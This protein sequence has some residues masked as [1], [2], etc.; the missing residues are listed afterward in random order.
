MLSLLLAN[1]MAFIILFPG[2]LLSIAIHEFAHA[3]SADKLG[4]PTPRLQGRV[5][6]NPLSHLDPIGTLMIFL[7]SFGWG[8]AVEFDPYNLKH[9]VRDTALIAL[10][11]PVANLLIALVLS[12]VIRTGILPWAWMYEAS[13]LI[14]YINVA[15]AIFNLVPVYPLDGSKILLALLPRSTAFEYDQFM[16]RY[17]FLV[18]I[19]LIFPFV[20]GVSPVTQLISP[21]IRFITGLLLA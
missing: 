13:S 17:G 21:V 14:V 7:T 18:L 20:G 19:F 5:T 11:G 16:H 10:A 3:W 6:L 8:R 1:P 9:P 15:L 4:D 2:L 12:L